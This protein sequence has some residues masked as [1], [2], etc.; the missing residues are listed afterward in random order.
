[1]AELQKFEEPLARMNIDKFHEPCFFDS[2]LGL[3]VIFSPKFG[4][5]VFRHIH[6]IIPVHVF[7]EI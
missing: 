2:Y 6:P 1:M 7:Y 5:L 4:G 3:A